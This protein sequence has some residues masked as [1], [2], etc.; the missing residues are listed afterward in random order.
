MARSRRF[1][2]EIPHRAGV[3][4]TFFAFTLPLILIIFNSMRYESGTGET[5]CWSEIAENS[6]VSFHPPGTEEYVLCWFT[7]DEN[8]LRIDGVAHQFN[9]N[10]LLASTGLHHL[11]ALRL[12]S[13]EVL[14]FNKPFLCMLNLEEESNLQGLFYHGAELPVLKLADEQKVLHAALA[15][16]RQELIAKPSPEVVQM[17]LQRVLM[18]CAEMYEQ[19]YSSVRI[20]QN[21]NRLYRSFHR[22]VDHHFRKKHTVSEYASLLNK[23]PKTICNAFR[24]AQLKSP[25]QCIQDRL[26]LE[27]R[28]LLKYTDHSINQISHELGFADIHSFSRFYK[29]RE[30][31]SP[32]VFRNQVR[33]GKIAKSIGKSGKYRQQVVE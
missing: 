10:D 3:V 7:D 4:L 15:M 6:G 21:Q 19:Q 14:V 29:N 8:S 2:A 23:S 33:K 11:E 27:A 16:L 22:L 30:G 28:R 18:L 32:S 5:L 31:I 24:N 1:I 17:I 9:K 13:A 26:H 12:T 20:N 25:L